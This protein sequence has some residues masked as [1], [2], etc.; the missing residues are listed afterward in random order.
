MNKLSSGRFL[1]TV[2]SGAVFAYAVVTK[3]IT[4][5]A[6]TAILSMVFISY[7]Q[8]DRKKEV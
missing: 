8:R 2:I 4:A 3:L 1:L 6:T 7:F 5:E